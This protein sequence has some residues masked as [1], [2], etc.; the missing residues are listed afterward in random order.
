MPLSKVFQLYRDGQF[1]W[2]MKPEY[3]EKTT[4]LPQ[5]TDKL[6][7]IK[8]CQVHLPLNGI[9]LTVAILHALYLLAWCVIIIIIYFFCFSFFRLVYE[10]FIIS[11]SCLDR[12][13]KT[14]I[15]QLICVL[16]GHIVNDWKRECSLLVM[17]NISV[18]IK[19]AIEFR[20]MRGRGGG[21]YSV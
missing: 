2:W 18:T 4:D 20:V 3:Q 9:C 11:S 1:Y 17:N 14:K 16:G 10:P 13:S 5:V 7:D 8:Q 19:V 6:Y 15:R 12:P 21:C